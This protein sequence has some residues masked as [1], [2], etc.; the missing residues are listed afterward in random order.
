MKARRAREGSSCWIHFLITR[1]WPWRVFLS[2]NSSL[3]C[4][5]FSDFRFS[6]AT[7]NIYLYPST[8]KRNRAIRV[9]H[10]CSKTPRMFWT[11]ARIFA[12]KEKPEK[13]HLTVN[14]VLALKVL[15][16][17]SFFWK[18]YGVEVKE[19]SAQH[20]NR[21]QHVEKSCFLAL[22]RTGE[23]FVLSSTT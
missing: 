17:Y 11:Q 18:P 10:V 13:L 22:S 8:P 14:S 5:L 1:I 15:T 6:S 4:V 9:N 23:N 16:P 2:T 12:E 19:E 20:F 7:W 3:K 21:F